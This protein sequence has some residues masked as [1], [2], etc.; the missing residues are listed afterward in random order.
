MTTEP[1]RNNMTLTAD[2]L[3]TLR[4]VADAMCDEATNEY[5][6]SEQRRINATDAR[7]VGGFETEIEDARHYEITTALACIGAQLAAIHLE[8]RAVNDLPAVTEG[9][10]YGTMVKEEINS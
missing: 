9:L 3:E 10:R 2:T 4:D 1:E 6:D 7:T 8:L 5:S